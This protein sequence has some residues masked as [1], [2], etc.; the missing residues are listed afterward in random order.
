LGASGVVADAD[1]LRD[2]NPDKRPW[3]VENGAEWEYAD[4]DYPG[5]VCGWPSSTES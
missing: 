1:L 4:F 5:E 3:K 2:G